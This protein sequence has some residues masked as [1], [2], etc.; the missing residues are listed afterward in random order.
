MNPANQASTILAAPGLLRAFAACVLACFLTAAGA[1]DRRE[2]TIES[3]L[4]SDFLQE[5][6]TVTIDGRLLATL[7][8]QQKGDK[9]NALAPYKPTPGPH[10]YELS[11]RSQPAARGEGV[12]KIAGRGWLYTQ[13]ELERDFAALAPLPPQARVQKLFEQ[14]RPRLAKTGQTPVPVKLH[15]AEPAKAIAAAE[16]RIGMKLPRE[17]VEAVSQPYLA[18]RPGPEKLYAPEQAG[19]LPPEAIVSVFD[20]LGRPRGDTLRGTKAYNR[21][22]RHFILA[23]EG[24]SFLIARDDHPDAKSRA[25][26]PRLQNVT[27]NE[28]T[29]TEDSD[30]YEFYPF[31]A[32]QSR[33]VTLASFL[34]DAALMELKRGLDRAGVTLL[35]EGTDGLRLWRETDDAGVLTMS[36]RYTGYDNIE[37]D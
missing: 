19:L 1:E 31:H 29:S 3:D 6:V 22:M 23:R 32:P 15:A 28:E 17:Y 33:N 37:T 10:A 25:A 13:R 14:W 30:A 16:A 5:T 18:L 27:I 9:T 26:E 36:L 7:K 34:G 8:T 12:L 21:T 20:W 4:H 2:W 11:G 35:G 24:D